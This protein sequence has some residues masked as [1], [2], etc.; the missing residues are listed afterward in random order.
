MSNWIVVLICLSSYMLLISV[1]NIVKDLSSN[2]EV[3]KGD[4]LLGGVFTW[5]LMLTLLVIKKVKDLR[6]RL[7]YKSLIE[8]KQGNIVWCNFKDVEKIIEETEYKF[9]SGNLFD[10]DFKY[11]NKDFCFHNTPNVR[12]APKQVWKRYKKY[13]G[14]K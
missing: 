6:K 13:R 7:K 2:A 1:N 10:A 5:L 8:D 3:S 4:I 12:Y 9:T 11:W 14:S